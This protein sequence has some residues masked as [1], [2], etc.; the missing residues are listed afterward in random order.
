[1]AP[2]IARIADVGLGHGSFP[3]T[4]VITGS[5]NTTVNSRVV[6]RI[7]DLLSPHGSPSPSPPHGRVI[8][9]GSFKTSVN[10]RGSARIGDFICCGG[11]LCTG[12]GNT[13]F[14]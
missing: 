2:P 6:A 4:L 9:T 12:S 1:M 10:S 7:G 3:P 13:T 14:G 5:S 8:C 11:L